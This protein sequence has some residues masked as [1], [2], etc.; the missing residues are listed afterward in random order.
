MASSETWQNDSIIWLGNSL[1]E[2]VRPFFT[3]M[4]SA[5]CFL[6]DLIM[7]VMRS[8]VFVMSLV[9]SCI[10]WKNC[11]LTGAML[12]FFLVPLLFSTTINLLVTDVGLSDVKLHM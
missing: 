7:E 11:C 2:I 3:K 1:C 6:C 9:S 12:S 4:S 5:Y 10:R 8:A